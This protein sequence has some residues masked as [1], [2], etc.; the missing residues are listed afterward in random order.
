MA[1]AAGRAVD[2]ESTQ[3]QAP[4]DVIGFPGEL[5]G[6]ARHPSR[7]TPFVGAY[8]ACGAMIIDSM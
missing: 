6:V 1:A 3:S 4:I 2:R 7:S 8:R 5:V